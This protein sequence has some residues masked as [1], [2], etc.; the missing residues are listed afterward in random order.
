MLRHFGTWHLAQHLGRPWPE[1]SNFCSWRLA[2]P[3][4][5]HGWCR[6]GVLMRPG[7]ICEIGQNSPEIVQESSFWLMESCSLWFSPRGNPGLKYHWIVD[8][9]KRQISTWVL[10]YNFQPHLRP[11][12]SLLRAALLPS[13]WLPP[14]ACNEQERRMNWDWV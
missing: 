11:L 12:H 14:G 3:M 5:W 7:N 4:C 2:A 9:W 8:H 1:H 6:S 13:L 10:G